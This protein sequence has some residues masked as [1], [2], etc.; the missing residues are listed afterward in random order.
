MLFLKVQA[1]SK[2]LLCAYIEKA[3]IADN[4]WFLVETE[5]FLSFS[6][7]SKNPLTQSWVNTEN[8][9]A[10]EVTDLTLYI[11]FIN[12]LNMALYEMVV[13]SESPFATGRYSL[14]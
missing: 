12:S 10:S 2:S 14:N 5:H 11:Y 9:K 3:V 1:S 13:D 8:V 6:S 4:R 7:Q